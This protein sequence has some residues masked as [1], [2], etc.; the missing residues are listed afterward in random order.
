MYDY[1]ICPDNSSEVF[2]RACRRIEQYF[3]YWHKEELLIDV[4]GSTIQ[5]YISGEGSITVY[6]SCYI[7]AVYITSDIALSE[8]LVKGSFFNEE[9]RRQSYGYLVNRR[10]KEGIT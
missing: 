10:E 8:E 7:G 3:P 5:T 6:D 4:D 1:T 9:R 2:K